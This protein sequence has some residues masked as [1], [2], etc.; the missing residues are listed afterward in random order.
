MRIV[1]KTVLQ[2]PVK[3]RVRGARV[4]R[5]SS[6]CGGLPCQGSAV[7]SERGT[8][9][10]ACGARTAACRRGPCR[11]PGTTRCAAAG[12]T[13]AGPGRTAVLAT[14]AALLIRR[15]GLW[16]QV[17][18]TNERRAKKGDAPRL[19]PKERNAR[20]GGT[21]ACTTNATGILGETVRL[22]GRVPGCKVAIRH[23]VA[24]AYTCLE[25]RGCMC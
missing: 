18:T 20:H 22:N 15:H 12:G 23:N 8:G 21:S 17:T 7:C 25:R 14:A 6:V 3:A 24:H 19:R 9:T 5:D 16:I 13:V 2:G 10:A 4:V 11:P 1:R